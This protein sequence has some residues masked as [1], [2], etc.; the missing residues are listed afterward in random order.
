MSTRWCTA[1]LGAGAWLLLAVAS[2]TADDGGA[3]LY[4]THCASCHGADRL[5]AIGPALLPENL[6]RLPRK[7]ASAVVAAGLPATQM[8][9]FSE[10]LTPSQIEAVVGHDDADFDRIRPRRRRHHLRAEPRRLEVDPGVQG[11]VDQFHGHT[12]SEMVMSL[13]S[14]R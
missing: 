4:A 2:A 10:I 3:A 11:K 12:S 7:R 14:A 5:G 6:G 1:A 8:P 13:R 9:A